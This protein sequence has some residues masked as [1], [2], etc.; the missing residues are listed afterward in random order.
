MVIGKACRALFPSFRAANPDDIWRQSAGLRNVIVHEYF[1]VDHEINWDVVE[2]DLP[3]LKSRVPA[4][5]PGKPGPPE[6]FP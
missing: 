5:I 1:G 3:I 4:Q 2:R 6:P